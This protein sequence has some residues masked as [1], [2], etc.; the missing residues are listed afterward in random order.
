MLVAHIEKPLDDSLLFPFAG[1]HSAR[2]SRL[3]FALM[4]LGSG[5]LSRKK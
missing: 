4:V 2:S 1:L 3:N 5:G